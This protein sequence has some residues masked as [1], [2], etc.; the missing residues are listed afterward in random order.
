M[1]GNHRV[2]LPIGHV[3]LKPSKFSRFFSIAGTFREFEGGQ[4]DVS[5]LA[6]CFRAEMQI[7]LS[8][9]PK[10]CRIVARV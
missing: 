5:V 1:D 7:G 10:R 9:A 6:Q 4:R 2:L 3:V 8:G